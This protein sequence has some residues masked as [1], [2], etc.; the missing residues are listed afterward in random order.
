MIDL[1]LMKRVKV[2]PGA[3][4]AEVEPG[5][6]LADFD[7]GRAGPRPR[8]AA[9]HQLHDRRRRAD[10]R[11]RLRLVEPQVRHDHRQPARRRRRDGRRRVR[12]APAPARTRTCSGA[13]AAAA[14]T[15]ASSPASSSSSIRSGRRC[16]PGWSSTRSTQAKSVLTQFARFTETMPDELNVWVV[17]R[18]APPLPF[19][20]ADV[21]G[22]EIVVLALCYAG[23]PAEGEKADRTAARVR[24]AAR[25]A[26]RRAAVRGVAAG[27]RSAADPG[28]RNYWKSHNFAQLGDGAIDTI[29]EYAGKLPSPA[30]RDLH[31]HDRRPDARAWRPTR[32]RTRAG[33]RSTS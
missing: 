12:C 8:H 1:S 24:H 29:I 16:C 7:R 9:R 21:H 3:R 5:C 15:S 33:T 14:A 2:D 4:R 19:L 32:W 31:R 20:P 27:V 13:C 17:T 28:A 22:K 18:K 6:T 26:H 23:D 30:V 25:R 11:R 10:A